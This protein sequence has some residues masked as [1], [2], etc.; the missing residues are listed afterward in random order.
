MNKKQKNAISIIIIIV[1]AIPVIYFS[2][3][4][5]QVA[6]SYGKLDSDSSHLLTT[7]LVSAA[8][9]SLFA[10]RNTTKIKRGILDQ[11]EAIE[12]LILIVIP[13]V[14][15]FSFLIKTYSNY[16]GQYFSI[17]VPLWDGLYW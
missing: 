7:I 15:G 1:Y 12:L 17:S 4:L 13:S 11:I 16:W 9:G 8:G 3:Q 14:E 6:Q 5:V 10:L 2:P